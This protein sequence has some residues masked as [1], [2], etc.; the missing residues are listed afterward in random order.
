MQE[1]AQ[2]NN[3]MVKTNMRE[4]GDD[5][6]LPP[7]IG[8]LRHAPRPHTRSRNHYTAPAPPRRPPSITPMPLQ[9]RSLAERLAA[10]H[11]LMASEDLRVAKRI[12]ESKQYY[13]ADI[14]LRCYRYPAAHDYA[15]GGEYPARGPRKRLRLERE[16]SRIATISCVIRRHERDGSPVDRAALQARLYP[17][18]KTYVR[19]AWGGFVMSNI[20]RPLYKNL[21]QRIAEDEEERGKLRDEVLMTSMKELFHGD[22]LMWFE[23]N[24]CIPV[25]DKTGAPARMT[26]E[27]LMQWAISTLR[28]PSPAPN[29]FHSLSIH[30]QLQQVVPVESTADRLRWNAALIEAYEDIERRLGPTHVPLPDD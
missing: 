15:P 26:W 14:S 17:E 9:R 29:W 30:E 11:A 23:Y 28:N 2:G 13:R 27:E 22:P 16:R 21:E 10:H 20:F 5:R 3:V 1:D 6:P 12:A 8:V 19:N 7:G 4:P 24:L 18:M 25:K